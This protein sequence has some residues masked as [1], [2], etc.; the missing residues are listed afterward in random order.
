M[1]LPVKKAAVLVA[2]ALFVA[3]ADGHAA[4]V[5]PPPRNAVDRDLP[6]WNQPMPND[7]N[8]DHHV[9]TPICPHGGDDGNLTLDN[10]QSCFWFSHGERF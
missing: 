8:W 7:K 3:G 6:P 9:D 4:M 1:P 5:F 2:L 10:G